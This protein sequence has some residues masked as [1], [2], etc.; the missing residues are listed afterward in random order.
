ML[1]TRRRV[2]TVIKAGNA[3]PILKSLS[4]V[5]LADHLSEAR[6]IVETAKAQAAQTVADAREDSR[7]RAGEAKETARAEGYKAG[8]AK[9]EIEGHAKAFDE[10]IKTFERQHAGVVEQMLN[11]IRGIEEIKNKLRIAAERDVLEFAV[12]LAVGLTYRIGRHAPKA[13]IE[14]A[15]RAIR[16]VGRRTDLT[17]RVNPK[18]LKAME[19]YASTVLTRIDTSPN[20]SVVA[21]E[22]LTVGGC[23]V[24]TD[25]SRV[26]A[27]LET[28]IAELSSLLLDHEPADRTVDESDTRGD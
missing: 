11:T 13:A 24:E 17:I 3:G 14:N 12:E 6:E 20:V 10:S 23:I 4:H 21:D 25:R 27:T 22:S 19:T 1:D 9:G 2:N 7:R 26:D 5:D 8:Y 28:Q 15:K 16:L 18:D